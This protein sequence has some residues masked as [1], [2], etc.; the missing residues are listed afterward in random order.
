MSIEVLLHDAF[1]I[2]HTALPQLGVPEGY[3]HG[4]SGDLGL[5]LQRAAFFNGEEDVGEDGLG[6]NREV[7]QGATAQPADGARPGDKVAGLACPREIQRKF[8]FAHRSGHTVRLHRPGP[9]GAP[10]YTRRAALVRAAT[11]MG[12]HPYLPTGNDAIT[13]GR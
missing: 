4:V 7:A 10:W 5:Y 8:L 13:N 6:G 3:S 2:A 9:E 11:S 12:P 1:E